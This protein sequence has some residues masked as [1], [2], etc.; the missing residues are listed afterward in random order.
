LK[1]WNGNEESRPVVPPL[2]KAL[3]IKDPDEFILYALKNIRSRLDF[4]LLD[5]K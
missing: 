2:M 3:K 5:L 1:D 4:K